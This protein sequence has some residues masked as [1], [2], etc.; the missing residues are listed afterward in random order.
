ME[1]NYEIKNNTQTINST[2]QNELKISSRLLYKL[3]KLNKIELNHKPCDTRKTGTFGDTITINFDY[4]ED[5]SNIIPTKMNLNIIFE[6]DWLL[7]VNKPAGIAIHPSVL[8]YSDSLCNGIKFYF[9]KI[10]LK[11][12]IRPVNRLDLNTSG[13][14]VFAKCEYIQECLINQMKNNQ[15]K[16]EYLAV[17]NGFF[18]KKSGTINLPI[19]RKENSI[20]ERCI[21]ENGQPAIT[22]YE[23]L[24]EFDN[25]SLV[26]CSLETGRT[27]QIRVHMSAIGH[28]LLGDSLYGSISDLINRQALHC[29]NLQ[30]IHPVYNNDL[31]FW[32]D[33][34]N[35]FKIFDIK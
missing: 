7:V 22:H 4:K 33:L 16:K 34:P 2:L 26:K 29:F 27:H 20:I 11:K 32:G 15:F 18:D 23:V 13:L 9:D 12:K 24:K 17:C 25:Y 8:H 30:F 5:N 21:S 10:G 28:P 31:N 1:I 14:V 3:I 6:D 35:D 19:A